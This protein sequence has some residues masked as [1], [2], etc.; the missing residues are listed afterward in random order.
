MDTEHI[1]LAHDLLQEVDQSLQEAIENEDISF[2]GLLEVLQT[3]QGRVQDAMG[4]I[5]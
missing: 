1:E 5:G 3:V 2:D 4:L